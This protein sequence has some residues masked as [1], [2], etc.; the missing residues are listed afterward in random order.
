[1]IA[2]RGIV[3]VSSLILM[4]VNVAVDAIYPSDH[5]KYSTKLTKDNFMSTLKGVIES[6]EEDKT[7]FVRWIASAE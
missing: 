3:I 4:V 6:S 1:M 2:S 7:L 5:W